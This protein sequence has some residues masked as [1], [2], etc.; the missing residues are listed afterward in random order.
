MQSKITETLVFSRYLNHDEGKCMIASEM[1]YAESLAFAIYVPLDTSVR[2][3][4]SVSYYHRNAGKAR[5]NSLARFLQT[6]PLCKVVQSTSLNA[7][8]RIVTPIPT[9][10][11]PPFT[12]NIQGMPLERKEKLEID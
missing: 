1:P 6:S 5:N 7:D 10:Q 9:T 4:Y 8:Y 11:R 2:S 3:L 12:C